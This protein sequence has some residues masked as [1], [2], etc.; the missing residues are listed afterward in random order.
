LDLKGARGRYLTQLGRALDRS[1]WRCLA[2]A[3][4]SNHIHLALVAGEQE[5]ENW[6]KRLHSP[7]A[8]WLNQQC[9]GLG[10][11]FADRP[12]MVIAPDAHAG[13]VL[14]YIHNNPVRA[15]VTR[16][17]G[18]SAWTSHRA[19][20]GKAIAPS[21]LRVEEGL[22]LSGHAG[23]PKT[24]D[25]WVRARVGDA[26]PFA[27]SERLIE[28]ARAG[29]RLDGTELATPVLGPEARVPRLR[30]ASFRRP[31]PALLIEV[32]ARVLGLDPEHVRR[33]ERASYE[34]RRIVMIAA[35]DFG[36]RVSV[37][38]A[39][40]GISRQLG[41]RLAS[42][43]RTDDE[44][45]LRVVAGQIRARVDTVDTVPIQV[46]GKTARVGRRK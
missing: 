34:A 28:S 2:F 44:F 25:A 4:M 38:S 1:D 32:V 5:P 41:S 16:T 39:E 19:Y 11:V 17:A 10:P 22:A 15:G 20:V 43:R 8:L 35:A 24:F 12:K 45:V 31:E 6:L 9:D 37:M 33:R 13:A 42:S 7:F 18:A 26:D 14:A 29:A 3:L 46:G 27:E 36:C 23:N 40:F 30:R 21:W